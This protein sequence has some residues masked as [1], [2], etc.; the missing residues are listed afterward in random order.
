MGELAKQTER[1]KECRKNIEVALIQSLNDSPIYFQTSVQSEP[2][3]EG[4]LPVSE[5]FTLVVPTF[6]NGTR[7][8]G[9]L[10]TLAAWGAW[11]ELDRVLLWWNDAERPASASAA[12]A[13][14]RAHV[15]AVGGVPFDVL[16]EAAPRNSLNTRWRPSPHI[17]TDVRALSTLSLLVVFG[18]LPRILLSSSC[19]FLVVYV[20]S[21][22]LLLL[23]FWSFISNLTFFFFYVFGRN[24]TFFYLCFWSFIS[25]DMD[26]PVWFV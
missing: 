13:Q 16:V 12:Q 9:L 4:A 22:L 10:R 17:R 26:I 8:R 15:A 25:I 1:K 3:R 7:V 20:E 24:L 6:Y 23:C 5:R 11:P 14:L 18:R 21:Y 2:A 19:M